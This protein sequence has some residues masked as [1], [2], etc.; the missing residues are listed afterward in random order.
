MGQSFS[1]LRL[2]MTIANPRTFFPNPNSD[3]DIAATANC[4]TTERGLDTAPWVMV[5]YV[6]YM[7]CHKYHMRTFNCPGASLGLVATA[8]VLCRGHLRDHG[9]QNP[10]SK[11]HA[12]A[13]CPNL[14]N[15]GLKLEPVRER[16]FTENAWLSAFFE[17]KG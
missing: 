16:T 12:V 17:R 9:A 2:R 5:R 15:G 13:P 11:N 1:S 7:S 14:D 10:R 4:T 8:R 6:L 3:R